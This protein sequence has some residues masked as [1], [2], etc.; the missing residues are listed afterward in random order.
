IQHYYPTISRALHPLIPATIGDC[1]STEPE[2]PPKPCKGN[3]ILYH[4]RNFYYE[5]TARWITGVNTT[6]IDSIHLE[7]QILSYQEDE[8][9]GGR[10]EGGRNQRVKVIAEVN[11]TVAELNLSLR[12]GQCLF[13]NSWWSPACDTLW[14]NTTSCC[15][16]NIT[17]SSQI[18]AVCTDQLPAGGSLYR[19]KK[20]QQEVRESNTEKAGTAEDEEDERDHEEKEEEEELK[21]TEKKKK[22]RRGMIPNYLSNLNVTDFRISPLTINESVVG[23]FNVTVADITS[24]VEARLKEHM[25]TFLLPETRLIPWNEEDEGEEEL[26]SIQDLLNRLIAVNA[27]DGFRCISNSTESS[28]SSS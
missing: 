25:Q 11:G 7:R 26:L 12:I 1:T 27:P 21:K 8:D 18:Q 3:D 13:P 17:F 22:K 10:S 4:Y 24:S 23:L 14:D 2:P 6:E 28:Y 5:A 16:R 19:R 20:K 9:G 15:G